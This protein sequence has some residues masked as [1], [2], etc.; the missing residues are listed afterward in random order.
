MGR[1]S[2]SEPRKMFLMALLNRVV[3]KTHMAWQVPYLIGYN[4]TSACVSHLSD[5]DPT[6]PTALLS[7][8][9]FHK[10]RHSDLN[11]FP[12]TLHRLRGWLDRSV[13]SIINTPTT[14]NS[15]SPSPGATGTLNWQPW[16][17]VYAK[18]TIGYYIMDCHPILPS[19]MLYS[20]LP[21]WIITVKMMLSLFQYPELPSHHLHLSRVLESRLTVNCHLIS[22]SL[23]LVNRVT[24]TSAPY[25][26]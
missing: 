10:D 11:C 16:S 3:I 6:L 2:G 1:G 15:T 26:M 5:G 21:E 13:C 14:V 4:P 18:F 22:T 20:L 9:W 19:L 24:F 17:N 12:C 7:T 23:T 8:L 25:V